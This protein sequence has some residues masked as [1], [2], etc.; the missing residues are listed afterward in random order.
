MDT[1]KIERASFLKISQAVMNITRTHAEKD[2]QLEKELYELLELIDQ[3]Q[4]KADK[5]KSLAYELA[6]KLG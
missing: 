6:S 3:E 4:V 1:N 5:V 2:S